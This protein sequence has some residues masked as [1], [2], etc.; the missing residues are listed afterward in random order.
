VNDD[1]SRGDNRLI[2]AS[3]LKMINVKEK[4]NDIKS[5]LEKQI[6]P[7]RK[8][9]TDNVGI[10][11][12]LVF[13]AIQDDRFPSFVH[14]I[15]DKLVGQAGTDSMT[16]E[17]FKRKFRRE[18]LWDGEL[19]GSKAYDEVFWT[20][21]TSYDS[22]PDRTIAWCS[23]TSLS[24]RRW[25]HIRDLYKRM[26]E[27]ARMDISTKVDFFGLWIDEIN[28]PTMASRLHALDSQISSLRGQIEQ[29]QKR[30]FSKYHITGAHPYE[31]VMLL[32]FYGEGAAE[33]RSILLPCAMPAD[34]T[35]KWGVTYEE[36][37]LRPLGYL[38]D[39]L[40][41][42]QIDLTYDKKEIVKNVQDAV[43]K[44][45]QAMGKRSEGIRKDAKRQEMCDIIER[46]FLQFY[47]DKVGAEEAL[48][49]TCDELDKVGITLTLETLKRR[50]IPDIKK[51]LGVKDL[52]ELLPK[53]KL[54]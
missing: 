23:I 28:D 39:G 27:T 43:N 26:A 25:A 19:A 33:E 20:D 36:S 48:Q 46:Y 21:L 9:I 42:L 15:W 29:G 1:D 35:K 17:A 18:P 3:E 7:L 12:G 40:L 6:E 41:Y 16:A 51:K 8:R 30:I 54:T 11:R 32:L 38:S 47:K 24:G 34:E 13:Q 5:E 53:K 37:V 14:V 45:Q 22:N 52:R 49:K 4:I 10:L 31:P 50:Y 44:A 2:T